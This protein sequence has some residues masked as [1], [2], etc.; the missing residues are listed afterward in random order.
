MTLPNSKL[1]SSSIDNLGRRKYRRYLGKLNL[2]YGTPPDRI[3][4]FCE[5]IRELVRRHPHTRKDFYAAYLNEF[6]LSSLDVLVVVFFEVPDYPTELRER[7]RLMADIL[8]L[9]EKAGVEFAYVNQQVQLDNNV[10]MKD[11]PDLPDENTTLAG[12]RIAADI[13]GELPNYQDRP[14]PVKFTSATKFD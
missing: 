1:A 7:H 11:P 10:F 13:A 9:A 12:A 4:A 3:D 8:R 5:G 6:T 2:E 14:G